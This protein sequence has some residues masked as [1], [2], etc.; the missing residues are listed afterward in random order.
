MAGIQKQ[1]LPFIQAE[2]AFLIAKSDTVDFISDIANNP[3]GYK[4]ASI[5][6]GTTGDVAVV[7]GDNSV[8]TF[9]NIPSGTFMPV[10]CKRVN[11]T[12]TTASD[13]LGLVSG[14]GIGM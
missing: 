14:T 5:F 12:N 3:D 11:S 9:K 7:F 4:I 6:V 1:K 10:V 13:M 2:D 8:Q